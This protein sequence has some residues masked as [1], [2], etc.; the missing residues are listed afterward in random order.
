MFF[1]LWPHVVDPVEGLDLFSVDPDLPMEV[2]A[3]G[4]AGVADEANGLIGL[5]SVSHINLKFG[6]VAVDGIDTPTVIDDGGVAMD[7][8][9]VGIDDCADGG[10]EDGGAD[11]SAKV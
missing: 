9:K 7:V 6:L 8:E 11:T 10:S 1:G 4:A 3:T 2:S 5:D